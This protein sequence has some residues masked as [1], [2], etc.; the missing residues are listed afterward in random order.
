[1]DLRDFTHQ[2]WNH[3]LS[4]EDDFMSTIKYVSVDLFNSHAYS[5][6][7][8]KLIL[9]IGSE[10]DVV[11]KEYCNYIDSIKSPS[12]INDYA[13]IILTHEPTI[14]TQNIRIIDTVIDIIPWDLW[15]GTHS[16]LWWKLYNKIKHQRTDALTITTDNSGL[17]LETTHPDYHR[18]D[19][20]R[21]IPY[22]K[23]ANQE[24]VLK[25]LGGLFILCM[26]FHKNISKGLDP[27]D[28]GFPEYESRLFTLDGWVKNLIIIDGG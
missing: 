21:G 22:Y 19:S 8:T 3:Y 28:D 27:K 7:Y 5:I 24:N 6:E 20:L 14:K 17:K 11:C 18:Y 26:Y 16:P 25:A 10:V 12:R 1:M 15:D 2:Y 23:F 13:P 9:G 4:I